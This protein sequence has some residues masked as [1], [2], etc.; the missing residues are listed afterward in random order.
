MNQ[1]RIIRCGDTMI[2]NGQQFH[3]DCLIDTRGI[4]NPDQIAAH[5]I[6]RLGLLAATND[7]VASFPWSTEARRPLLE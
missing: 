5:R 6:D 1:V 3:P 4:A 7:D 2:A